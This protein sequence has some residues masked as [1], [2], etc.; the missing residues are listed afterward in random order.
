MHDT[1]SDTKPKDDTSSSLADTQ[2]VRPAFNPLET[3]AGIKDLA[4]AFFIVP[5]TSA[6]EKPIFFHRSEAS[7]SNSLLEPFQNEGMPQLS[8]YNPMT[9]AIMKKM[10]HDAQNPIGLGGG[11]GILIPLKPTLTKSQ[12]EDSKLHRRIDKSSYGL[13]YDPDTPMRQLTQRL[14][15]RFANQASISCVDEDIDLP[16]YLFEESPDKDS[17]SSSNWYDFS[18]DEEEFFDDTDARFSDLEE[19]LSLKEVPYFDL[20]SAGD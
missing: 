4:S 11:R 7:T 12:L 17:G 3:P 5:A 13:G 16:G 1:D 18:D 20:V 8:L 2:R 15:S 14:Q 19:P 9:Q 10:G 6:E